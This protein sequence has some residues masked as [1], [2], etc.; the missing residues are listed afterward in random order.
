M[1]FCGKDSK[2]KK[3]VKFLLNNIE[4]NK[5]TNEFTCKSYSHPEIIHT[6]LYSH[7]NKEWSCS[8]EAG[9]WRKYRMYESPEQKYSLRKKWRCVHMIASIIYRQL[10]MNS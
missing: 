10:M 3:K 8:C 2:K 5:E 4:Y 1:F 7:A 6:V 9:T